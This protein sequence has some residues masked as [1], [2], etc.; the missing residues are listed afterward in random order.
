MT[1]GK[2][3]RLPGFDDI[4]SRLESAR[5]SLIEALEECAAD[6]FAR[7]RPG[8]ESVKK[9]ME[10]AVDEV[11]FYYGRLVAKALNLPQPPCMSTADFSSIRE[12]A[13]SFQ[14]AHRRFGNL[15]HDLIPEDL[16]RKAEDEHASY[17]LRQVLE[18]AV[19][20]YNRRCQQLK[21]L[22]AKPARK[23]R[24]K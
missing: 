12:A 3:V 20:H 17:T 23:P 13:M 6:S 15:L 22:A 18:M 21:E 7:E 1:R 2:T 16:D 24:A 4:L 10:L 5:V 14:V 9:T 11:N 8:G 19:A